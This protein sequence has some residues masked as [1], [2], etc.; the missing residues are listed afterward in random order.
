MHVD[1][2]ITGRMYYENVFKEA[3]I[4]VTDGK[5]VFIGSEVNAP[6]FDEKIDFKRL[7]I[8]PG[9]I[10]IHTH[11]RGMRFKHKEDFLTGTSAAAAGGFTLVIDMPNTDPPTNT[12]PRLIEKIE[13]AE[14][15]IVVDT[16]FYFGRPDSIRDAE[17]LLEAGVVGLKLYSEDYS[18]EESP[19]L[20]KIVNMAKEK[21]RK[22]VFHP[23]DAS[24][25][26]ASRK[27]YPELIDVRKHGF[28][29]PVEAEL[30]ALD[31]FKRVFGP[32]AHAAHLTT[33]MSIKKAKLN[34]FT[35][36]VSVNHLTLTDNDLISLGGICKVNPPLRS[37][38]ERSLL[39]NAFNNG[40]VGILVTDHAPHTPEE[41]NMTLY[42][43]IPS[44]IPGLETAL[45][46]LLDRVNKGELSL[47]RIIDAFTTGPAGFLW[48]RSLGAIREGCAANLTVIDIKEEW[49]VRA[50]DFYSK[51]KYS[52]FDGKV[53]KGRVKATVVRGVIVYM[54]GEIAVEKGFG[55][56]YRAEP[57]D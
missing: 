52:P 33:L 49:R 53:L 39:V 24:V 28:I 18:K 23:E 44:G 40:D 48:D 22:I 34:G 47:H 45:P 25:I 17:R 14:S 13:E 38:E 19:E 3:C 27:K 30:S 16:G 56:I 35:Y 12:Y 8:L 42:D 11:L 15:E 29:R 50:D 55:R 46:V 4:G 51:A 5:I 1:T 10:D 20:I 37:Q 6:S 2:L 7:L 26:E 54:E 31:F 36:D 21:K 43:E 57:K 32:G 41:K 9:L